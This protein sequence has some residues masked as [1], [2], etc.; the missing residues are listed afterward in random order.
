MKKFKLFASYTEEEHW[1]NEQ[2]AAGW[3]LTRKRIVYTFRKTEEKPRIYAIDY[4][5]FQDAGWTHVAGYR[6]SGEQYFSSLEEDCSDSSIFS[7]RESSQYRYQAKLRTSLNVLALVLL[8]LWATT[9][10]DGGLGSFFSPVLNPKSA[11]LTPGLWEATGSEF[12]R[13][14]WFELP[15][16]FIFRILPILLVLGCLIQAVIYAFWAFYAGKKEK[17]L[18]N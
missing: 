15:V 3:N 14:F 13:A 18:E 9:A 10:L 11:F 2:S 8:Y 5:K 4:R 6:W 17:R 1:L 12:W 7:D 16:A